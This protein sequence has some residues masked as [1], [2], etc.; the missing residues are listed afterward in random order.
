[1]RLYPPVWSIG[2]SAVEEDV[3]GG[4]RIP[5]GSLIFMS[6]ALTQRDPRFWPNPEGF[7]PDRFLPEEDAKRPKGAYFP[8]LL[9]PRKC[10]GETFALME[11]RLLLATLVQRSEL[12]LVS[13]FRTELDPTVTLRPKRGV[14][15]TGRVRE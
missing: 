2:R 11:A 9:G 4:Y 7:D 6:P 5:K 12:S 10:I 14:W 3:I 8:F 13:G 15:M 1:M